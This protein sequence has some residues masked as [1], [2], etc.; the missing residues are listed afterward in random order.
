MVGLVGCRRRCGGGAGIDGGGRRAGPSPFPQVSAQ[1]SAQNPPQR[2]R[3]TPDGAGRSHMWGTLPDRMYPDQHAS[4]GR[5][6]T[7]PHEHP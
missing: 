5:G 2:D 6:R 7:R 4:N 3:T 1:M